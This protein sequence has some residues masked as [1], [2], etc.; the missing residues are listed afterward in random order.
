M[1]ARDE[2]AAALLECLRD[3]R[4]LLEHSYS[5]ALQQQD[6]LTQSDAEAIALACVSQD[7]ILR[8]INQADERAAAISEKIIEET[9]LKIEAADAKAMIEVV[10]ARYGTLIARELNLIP[11]IARQV[12]EANEVNSVLLSNGLD[13]ITSCLRIV[14]RE[15]EPTVYSKDA[16]F[17]GSGHTALSLDSR[18]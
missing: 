15:P 14:A 3:V 18:V 16:N 11:E 10:G 9:G 6:A 1:P 7:D 2:L 5:I 17:M 13:I 4:A 8:R 12:R